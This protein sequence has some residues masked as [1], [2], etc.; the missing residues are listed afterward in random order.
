MILIFPLTPT[1]F[2]CDTAGSVELLS[3]GVFISSPK[4]IP[5]LPKEGTP[6]PPRSG[7]RA[8]VGV[9]AS[10]PAKTPLAVSRR[11]HTT[12]TAGKNHILPRSKRKKHACCLP[13]TALRCPEPA[14]S[15]HRFQTST[16]SPSNIPPFEG[17]I[18][19]M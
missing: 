19:G 3:S 4:P 6:R 16:I 12:R 5:L 11:A 2:R 10:P 17:G 15:G 7:T 14:G 9:V 13:Q 8:G 18:G 1:D